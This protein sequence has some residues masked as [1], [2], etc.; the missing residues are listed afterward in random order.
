M[1]LTKPADTFVRTDA[2]LLETWRNLMGPFGFSKRSLWL[3]FIEEDGRLSPVIL[4][5]DGIPG[6]PDKQLL[7]NLAMVVRETIRRELPTSA[8]FLLSRPGAAAVQDTDR[9]WAEQ[10]A[11]AVDQELA[12]WP[13]YLATN[14]GVRLLAAE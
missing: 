8:A 4:P 6:E 9:H 12:P 3:I 1:T 13:M 10:L 5:I 2:D 11:A 7:R 14:D